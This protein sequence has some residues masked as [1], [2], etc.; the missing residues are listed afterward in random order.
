MLLVADVVLE[1][2]NL[3]G[4]KHIFLSPGQGFSDV[5]QLAQDQGLCFIG[6][7]VLLIITGFEDIVAQH[8]AIISSVLAALDKIQAGQC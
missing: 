2:L 5:G 3:P 4:T 8:P 1:G 6:I 7:K